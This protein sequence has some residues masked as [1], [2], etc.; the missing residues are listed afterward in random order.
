M[1][2][3]PRWLV[4]LPVLRGMDGDVRVR[5][6]VG[7]D[8]RRDVFV[9]QVSPLPLQPTVAREWVPLFPKSSLPGDS[10]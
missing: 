8:S 7:T 9:A 4:R 6:T 2:G 3:A 1:G 5:L 10:P